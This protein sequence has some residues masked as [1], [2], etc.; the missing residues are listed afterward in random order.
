MHI[1]IYVCEGIAKGAGMIEPNMATMLAYI[2][3]DLDMSKN[4]LD[5]YIHY[6]IYIFTTIYCI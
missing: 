3:T 1:C 5:R 2:V 6:L 4:D